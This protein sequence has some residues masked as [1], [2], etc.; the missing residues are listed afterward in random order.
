[1]IWA[2]PCQLNNFQADVF[3][4]RIQCS[5]HSA[6]RHVETNAQL[7]TTNETPGIQRSM[8]SLISKQVHMTFPG[9]WRPHD[10]THQYMFFHQQTT[11]TARQIQGRDILQICM[12]SSQPEKGN[13]PHTGHPQQNLIHFLGNVGTPTAD[14]CSSRYYSTVSSPCQG[15][16]S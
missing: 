10:K 15:K 11:G 5:I 9:D 6:Q 3:Y 13:K 4:E 2:T 8:D 7:L 14:I 12:L 16:K 1:M